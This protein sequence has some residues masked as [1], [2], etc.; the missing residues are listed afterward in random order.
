M[1]EA[2]LPFL[3]YVV[4]QIVV[5]IIGLNIVRDRE[6]GFSG[7]LKSWIFGQMLCFAV[8]QVLA[9]PMILLRWKFDVLFWCY[10]G[11][12]TVV[13]GFG[14]WGLKGRQIRL[15]ICWKQWTWLA[16]VLAAICASLILWQSGIYFFGMHLDEDDAR[17]LAEANDALVENRMMVINYD[18]GEL[19]NHFMMAEDVSSPWPM[20]NAMMSKFFH[21]RVSIFAHTIYSPVAIFTIYGI[22]W[23]IGTELFKKIE[24]RLGFL[25]FTAVLI[26]FYGGG[27]YSQGSFSLIRIWQ[28]KASVAGI[29][30]PMLLYLFIWL[31]KENRISGWIAVLITAFAGCLMS[32]IGIFLSILMIGGYG[33]YNIIVYKNW[34]RIPLWLTSLIPSVVSYLAHIIAKG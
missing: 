5:G 4:L 28:G 20:I 32:G 19:V 26:L 18:T 29:I 30:I 23:L 34:K 7:L 33:L 21:T 24:S 13:F 25:L 31:N 2:Y 3:G 8:F 1:A 12:M 27:V 17:W 14:C 15:S 22:Y 10:L 16:Y 6:V 11:S 9:V